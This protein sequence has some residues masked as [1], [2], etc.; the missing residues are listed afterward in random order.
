LQMLLA[1]CAYSAEWFNGCPK[2]WRLVL[3]AI[4]TEGGPAMSGPWTEARHEELVALARS[5]ASASQIAEKIGGTRNSIIGRC[6][7][8]GIKL[9]VGRPAPEP[10]AKPSAQAE[11]YAQARARTS[12]RMGAWEGGGA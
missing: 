6:H 7:R 5:G 10:K 11:A 9:G 4:D 3:D 12:P 8:A 1:D 2:T